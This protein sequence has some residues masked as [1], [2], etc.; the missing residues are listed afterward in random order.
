MVALLADDLGGTATPQ[1]SL[2]A[3]A[4]WYRNRF[5]SNGGSVMAGN[6]LPLAPDGVTNGGAVI[7]LGLRVAIRLDVKHMA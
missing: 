2:Y 6:R 3:N 1:L 4:A 7:T 5:G